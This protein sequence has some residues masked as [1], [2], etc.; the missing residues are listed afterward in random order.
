MFDVF[1]ETSA[2]QR[3]ISFVSFDVQTAWPGFLA[4]PSGYVSP[5]RSLVN[6]R[7]GIEK[8]V[9]NSIGSHSRRS[10]R[11]LGGE[12]NERQDRYGT[13]GTKHPG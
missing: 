4:G 1:S 8:A 10:M 11:L 9:T 3:L 13:C 6:A 2:K 5:S 7:V 12:R